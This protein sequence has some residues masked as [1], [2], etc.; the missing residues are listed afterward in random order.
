MLTHVGMD[1]ESYTTYGSNDE[2][3][4]EEFRV[5]STLNSHGIITDGD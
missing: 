1:C 3:A 5:D 4:Q 2:W